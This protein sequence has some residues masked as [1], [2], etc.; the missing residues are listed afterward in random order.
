MNIL[1]IID[2]ICRE[3]AVDGIYLFGSTA[4]GS[5]TPESDVDIA[6]LFSDHLGN[7]LNAHMRV[8]HLKQSLE[9]KFK[10]YDKL[11]LIDI[12]LA[13]TALQYAAIQGQTL[14]QNNPARLHRFENS[15]LNKVEEKYDL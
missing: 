11:D 6:I 10:C 2:D 5:A 3:H 12:E 4:D 14:V 15:V 13:P 8:Q 1:P 7:N 9:S